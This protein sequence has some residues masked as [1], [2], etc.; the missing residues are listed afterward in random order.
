M[1][2]YHVSFG[3]QVPHIRYLPTTILTF[4]SDV[5]INL[6]RKVLHVNT[7]FPNASLA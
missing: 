4:T 6:L 5:T 7:M 2:F 1:E 3:R